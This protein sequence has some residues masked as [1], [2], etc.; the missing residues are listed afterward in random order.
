MRITARFKIARAE[1]LN[2]NFDISAESITAIF[3]V[4]GCGKTSLLRAIA[5]LEKHAGSKLQVGNETWQ[6]DNVFLAPHQRAIG[7]VFQE[8][9]LFEHL[10]VKEN[11]EY[12]YKR[13]DEAARKFSLEKIISLLELQTLLNRKPT[14]LS[15]G[16]RQRVAIARA[17]AASPKLLL[18][19]EPLSS[20][21]Q[22]KKDELLPYIENLNKE[23]N[24]P[25]IY[26]SHSNEEIARLADQLI[27][28]EDAVVK[29][30]GPISEL[31]TRSDLSLA[32][33]R[34]A[35]SLIFAEVETYDE[36]FQLNYLSSD[37]GTFIVPGEKF[38]TGRKIRLRLAAQDISITLEAQKNT[39]ILNIFPAI[40]DELHA[41]DK[42]LLTVRLLINKFPVLAK[43][44]LKSADNLKLEKG[45]AVFAQIKSV[46]VLA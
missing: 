31:L 39:S 23:M 38:H 28:I 26:V 19:D 22:A 35:E 40:I 45:K 11:I 24:I 43:I 37:L 1:L 25:I 29:A 15:G 36:S 33:R 10:T 21:D 17:L 44:T 41:E 46:A 32:H 12:G 27:F 34:Q 7:Y 14:L 20:L 42:A 9:S 4:S 30:S 13:T 8:S 18:M 2:F 16:E 6:D 5:G 3:G